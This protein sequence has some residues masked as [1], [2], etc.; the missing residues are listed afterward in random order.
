MKY[1]LFILLFVATSSF[2]QKYVTEKSKVLF[3]SAAVL[4]DITATN[5]KATGILNAATSEFAFSIPI[6][7]FEFAKS[8]MKEHF[9]EK[10]LETE[11]YPRGT[12]TG[13]LSGFDANSVELQKVTANGKL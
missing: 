3:F 9:N 6:K 5:A 1:P 4:E 7:E 11:K 12:F 13:K 8:L 10:Y 2:A